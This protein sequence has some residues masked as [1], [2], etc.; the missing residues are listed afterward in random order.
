MLDLQNIEDQKPDGTNLPSIE[1]WVIVQVT[2]RIQ[3]TEAKRRGYEL[4]PNW[5]RELDETVNNY[6]L[7]ALY[8]NTIGSEAAAPGPEDAHLAYVRNQQR[9]EQIDRATLETLEFPDSAAVQR[10]LQHAGHHHGGGDLRTIAASAP[11]APPVKDV[12]ITFPSNDP[13]WQRLAP[14]LRTMSRGD[15]IGPFPAHGR[16]V[17]AMLMEKSVSITPFEKLS[18]ADRAQ[19]DSEATEFTRERRFLALLDELKRRYPVTKNT[20][21]LT[22]LPWPVEPTAS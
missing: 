14:T 20:A 8:A 4:D 19:L 22:K 9:F 17:V 12:E 5:R 2:R 21:L 10:F 15:A 11:G 18:P 1:Q 6:V 16:L 3:T 13:D 7:D